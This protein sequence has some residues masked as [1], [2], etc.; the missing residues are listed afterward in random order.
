[1]KAVSSIFGGATPK[2]QGPDPAV[3]E[4][5]KRQE[6]KLAEQEREAAD[7]KR[8]RDAAL[9]GAQGRG[10]RGA[11]LFASETGTKKATLGG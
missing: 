2:V 11:T 5:Q 8:S 10:S 6:A 1:M 7:E 3:L 4:A 9:A